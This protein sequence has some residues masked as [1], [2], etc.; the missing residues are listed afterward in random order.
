MK[1]I[2]KWIGIVLGSLLGLILI[3]AAVFYF[4]GVAK[5]NK[6]YSFPASNIVVPTDE[7]SIAYGK[8]RVEAACI[9][10]HGEDLSG[11]VGFVTIDSIISLDSAN[12]TAGKGGIGQR[13]TSDEDYVNAIRHGIG[14]D[15]KFIFMPAVVS[16]QN[17][18]DKDLGAMIAYLKTLPPVDRETN[19]L[20]PSVLGTILFGA[21]LFGE[22]PVETVLHNSNIIAPPA[23]VTVEF[24]EYLVNTSGCRD[25]HGENLAGAVHPDPTIAVITPNLTPGGELAAWSQE[26]FVNMFR[27]GVTPSGHAL[28]G[29]R[30]PWEEIANLNDDDLNAIFLYLQSLPALPQFTNQ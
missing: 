29:E 5:V 22:A 21:G 11:R 17:L 3:L 6:V 27:T 1:K 14:Q 12:L 23:A 10:C 9:F 4:V 28:R 8:Y 19:G 13:Y 2:V 26:D 24:G 30:M 18:S 20:Q 15:G 16:F 25:C 7:A